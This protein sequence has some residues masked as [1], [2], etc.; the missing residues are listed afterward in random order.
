MTCLQQATSLYFD[1]DLVALIH[2]Q[3]AA[4]WQLTVGP[5]FFVYLDDY[6]RLVLSPEWRILDGVPKFCGA[7]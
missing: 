3:Q 4:E 7:E 1:C 5:L 2:V 6:E